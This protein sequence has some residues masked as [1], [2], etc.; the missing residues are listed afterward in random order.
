[1]N[2]RL[3]YPAGARLR[4]TQAFFALR[5][6][7]WDTKFGHDQPAYEAAVAEARIPVGAAVADVGCGTGRALPALR[8]AVGAAGHVLAVDGTPEILD[9]VR[10]AGLIQHVPDPRQALD[11]LARV[12]RP[13]ARL[14]LFHP[15]GRATLAARHGQTLHP[16]EPLASSPRIRKIAFTG[17]TTTGRLIMQFAGANLIPVTLELGGKS[18]NIFFADVAAADDDFYDKALE[19]FTMFALNQGEVCTC[20]SRALIQESIYDEFLAD[21]AVRTRAIIQGNP[22]DTTTMIGAQAGNDQ[23]EKILS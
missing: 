22:L 5:A 1:L 4:E 11:E 3:T 15:S 9:A 23:L 14:I 18:P 8:H 16:D 2:P 20:P 7:D 12:T 17:E 13:G 21:S 6:A 10:A 19:G